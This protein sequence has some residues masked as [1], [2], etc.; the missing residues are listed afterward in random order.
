MTLAFLCFFSFSFGVYAHQIAS[1][2]LHN[3]LQEKGSQ[4]LE[5]EETFN[6]LITII[7]Q[8]FVL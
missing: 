2:Y 3:K 1:I 6:L 5:W 7:E 8:S 4:W